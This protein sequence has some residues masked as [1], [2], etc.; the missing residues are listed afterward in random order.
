M[1]N[2]H[3]DF[4][5]YE[6]ITSD[7]GAAQTFYGPLLGWD[8]KDSGTPGMDYRIFSSAISEVGG[9]MALTPEMKDGGARPFWVGYIAVDDV[10]AA[11]AKMK[12]AGAAKHMEPWDIP[13]VGRIAFMADPQGAMFYIMK[14]LSA[15]DSPDAASQSFAATEPSEGHCAWNELNSSDPEAAKAFYG[16]L[17]GWQKEGEMDMGP[18]GKYEFLK[19]GDDRGFMLGAV[20]PKP[21]QMPFSA[22]IYYFRVA[23]IDKAAQQIMAGGGSMIQEPVE[24]PG[25]EF[26]LVARDPQGAGFGLVGM[27]K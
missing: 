4:I 12:A 15:P 14:P 5:W 19:V 8:F 17:F 13:G 21:P 3:G 7:A 10:D 24:I 25:G 23:D 26:S 1:P 11:A 27:R 9:I 16:D 22:W 6:L 18:M 20:M 2:K